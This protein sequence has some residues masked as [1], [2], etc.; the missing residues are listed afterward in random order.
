MNINGEI[1][2]LRCGPEPEINIFIH[3]YYAVKN[4][5]EF[6]AL[7]SHILKT[8]TRGQVYLFFWRSGDLKYEQ[9]A[10]SLAFL[11]NAYRSSKYLRYLKLSPWQ[12]ASQLCL[13]VAGGMA[14]KAVLPVVYQVPKFKRYEKKAERLGGRLKEILS[15]RVGD[16][17]QNKV[18]LI[19]H[20]LGAR[21]IYSALAESDWSDLNLVDCVMLGGAVDLQAPDWLKCIA[22]VKGRVIN[23]YSENDFVLK[24]LKP[25]KAI[26][27]HPLLP[28]HPRVVNARSPSTG[29]LDYWPNLD[30]ILSMA[31]A[32]YADPQDP[33]P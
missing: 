3:G 28:Q 29:H 2:L 23:V 33:R 14:A 1:V 16:I 19:G 9:I 32:G 21:I 13:D 12:V 22:R 20:S 31:W 27:R 8:R 15:G 5:L 4:R 7:A 11:H 17:R 18:N 25:G 30:R 10:G 6:E 26:G 24:R